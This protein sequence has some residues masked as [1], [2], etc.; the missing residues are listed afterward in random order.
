MKKSLTLLFIFFPLL[1][2]S[3]QNWTYLG[4]FNSE[5]KPNLQNF[6]YVGAIDVN[7]ENNNEIYIGSGSSGLFYTTD[8]GKNWSC[9]TDNFEF[10]LIGVK[11]IIVDYS[12]NPRTILLANGFGENDFDSPNWGILKSK[13][14]G[15]TWQKT[16]KNENNA[17][18]FEPMLQFFSIENGA[19]IFALSKKQIYVSFNFGDSW[20]EL[21]SFKDNMKEYEMRDLFVSSNGSKIFF[22]TS[23]KWVNGKNESAHIFEINNI[24][25]NSN[26]N[27]IVLIDEKLNEIFNPDV[28]NKLG[29]YTFR[30]EKN[31]NDQNQFF[32]TRNL[33]GNKTN[34]TIYEFDI[35][36]GIC[37]NYQN[38]TDLSK[39]F[40]LYWH[41]GMK[42]N[43][44]NPSINYVASMTLLK[45]KN[46]GE[47]YEE[48]F[49]YSTGDNN[50]P[51]C[52][53]R[54]LL[55]TKYSEDGETDE[56]YLGTDGGLSYSNNGGKSWE[57]LSGL[58][59]PIAQFYGLGSSPFNGIISAGSQDN[60][61]MTYLPKEKKWIRY[62]L[63]DG[64]DVA[65]SK[66]T[67]G[68]AAGQYNDQHVGFTYN[69]IIPFN[70]NSKIRKQPNVR[71]SQS[72][73]FL[74]NGNLYFA[75][76][77]FHVLDIEKNEWQN[78]PYSFLDKSKTGDF[79]VSEIDPKIIYA[80][81]YWKDLI[82]SENGGQT[83]ENLSVLKMKDG[84]TKEAVRIV[85]ICVSPN[86]KDDVWIGIGYLGDYFDDKKATNRIYYSDDGGKSWEDYSTGLGIFPISDLKFVEGSL[87]GVLASTMTGVYF[88]EGRFDTWKKLGTNLPKS[89]ISEIDLNYCTGKIIVSTY[90]RGIWETD[91]PPIKYKQQ[92]I[93][94]KSEVWKMKDSNDVF[95]LTQ[96]VE[97]RKN[98]TLIIDTKVQMPKGGK[99]IVRN[100]NQVTFTENGKLENLCGEAF[101]GI[102]LK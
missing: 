96:D 4:P 72:L 84:S 14:G 35:E 95:L 58:S 99:I 80:S 66:T 38:N 102:I 85:S 55:I 8:R 15:N 91:F 76:E 61:I 36:K 74:K 12:K 90:G 41:D 87:N 78:F 26:E 50:I 23:S 101:E 46:K 17:I 100:K 30:F 2:F 47:T 1:T 11:D 93:I 98:A 45:S 37:I 18:I 22:S 63:G 40:D 51:H 52:D 3:Q 64:Y 44:L 77:Q 13:D 71:Q 16:M 29:N 81:G 7:P 28:E 33:S 5:D 19:K 92:R 83:W 25:Y 49:P 82:K 67:P 69:D 73:Q 54:K 94:K 59:L 65:Y 9:L 10:P 70:N 27:K 57:N 75:S 79:A 21:F 48:L 34:F 24:N 68:F 88:R 53:L 62:V 20:K 39:R 31:L 32:I 6:G 43:Q 42:I 60:S 56:I 97:L 89:I 86:N